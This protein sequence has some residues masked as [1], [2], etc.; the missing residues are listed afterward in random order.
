LINS[1]DFPACHESGESVVYVDDDTDMV[2]HAN[3]D[4][5]QSL[6][7]TEACNSAR[8][9]GDNRLCVTGEKSKLMVIGTQKLKSHKCPRKIQI[10]VNGQVIDESS[11]EKLLGVV[12]NNELTW[13]SH[14]HGDK[15]NEGLISQLSKRVGIIKHLSKHMSRPRLHEFAAAMFYSKLS[16]CLPVFGHVFGLE[17]YKENNSRYSSFTISDNHKLQVL[18]NKLNRVITGMDFKT[19]TST[20]F[21]NQLL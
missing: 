2:H 12:V 7:Q 14:I 6:I 15:N 3:L 9:L 10:I 19:P 20:L 17:I 18:Q 16:Y 4:E 5:L 11:S 21:D 13:K 8:W 1:N